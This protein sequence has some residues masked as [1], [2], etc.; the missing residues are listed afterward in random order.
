[1]DISWIIDIHSAI[2]WYKLLYEKN[3]DLDWYISQGCYFLT[4]KPSIINKKHRMIRQL[5]KCRP[6]GHMLKNQNIVAI[7]ELSKGPSYQG[8]MGKWPFMVGSQLK[9]CHTLPVNWTEFFF[10][11]KSAI[12]AVF[13]WR[14]HLETVFTATPHVSLV[15]QCVPATWL[16]GRKIIWIPALIWRHF[17]VI[18]CCIW[19]VLCFY[20]FGHQYYLA[21][22]FF[23]RKYQLYPK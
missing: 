11:D 14:V 23:E 17:S 2:Y 10:V 20:G 18:C 16:E 22:I 13:N 3:F 19:V 4:S 15:S 9:A 8:F 21:S 6:N 7:A 12:K 1:M 5:K